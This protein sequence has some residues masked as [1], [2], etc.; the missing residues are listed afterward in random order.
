M[1]FEFQDDSIGDQ[2]AAMSFFT[3]LSLPAAA[4]AMVT[5]LGS[6]EGL[7]GIDLATDA[8]NA[9]SDYVQTTFGSESLSS[10]V[11]GLFEENRSGLLTVSLAVAI[12]SLSRGFAGLVRGL[13]VAYDIET[14]RSWVNVR[15]VG[16]VIG[17][18]TLGVTGLAVYLVY[19]LWPSSAGPVLDTLGT[20]ALFFGLTAW[21][22]TLFHIAPDHRT[23]WRWDV[24][25]ALL[26]S[27]SWVLLA[28]GFATYVGLAGTGNGAV[29][30]VGAALLAFTLVYL[31]NLALLLGAELNGILAGRAG[32]ARPPRR[33]HHLTRRSRFRPSDS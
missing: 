9:I 24:P 32:I 25:G 3:L 11:D 15:L 12:Y 31:L 8:R 22:A 14:S 19:G 33:L 1:W 23:P 29:G 6:L 20:V 7:V 10:T 5:G 21:A 4:L 17:F 26:A 2:A 30:A 27:L 13:D 18:G 16:V 28:T